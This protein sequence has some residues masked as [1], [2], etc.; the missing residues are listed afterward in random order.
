MPV[1][2]PM[3]R[4]LASAVLL[5]GGLGTAHADEDMV[6]AP[7]HV[8]PFLGD[9]VGAVIA[10][11]GAFGPAADTTIVVLYD[12]MDG[13]KGFALVPDA[14]AKHGHRKLAL[15]G[16]NEGGPSGELA[17]ALQGNLDQDADDELV[18]ELRI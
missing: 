3:N 14:K 9:S 15:P 6:K 10:P 13:Y 1:S 17:V 2:T 12:I 7:A 5:L 18:V 4:A 11:K 16:F 8:K